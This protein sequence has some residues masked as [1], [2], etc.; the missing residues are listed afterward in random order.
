M[1][2]AILTG[3]KIDFK[4]RYLAGDKERNIITAK[5]LRNIAIYN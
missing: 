5:T 1:G 4:I 2:A 3:D